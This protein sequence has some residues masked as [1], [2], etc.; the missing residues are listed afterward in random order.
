MSDLERQLEA[1]I[2]YVRMRRI[3]K[4]Q[5]DALANAMHENDI[6]REENKLLEL[7]LARVTRP[8]IVA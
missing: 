6:L 1:S 4:E 8:R 5:T 2:E 3:L 7:K